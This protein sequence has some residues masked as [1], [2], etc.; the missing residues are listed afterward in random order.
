MVEVGN[1]PEHVP[2]IREFREIRDDLEAA[3]EWIK[4]RGGRVDS[5]RLSTYLSDLNALEA[6]WQV[7]GGDAL[8]RQKSHR[9]VLNSLM[10]A[11]AIGQVVKILRTQNPVPESINDK[12]FTCVCGPILPEDENAAASSNRA[13]NFFFELRLLALFLTAGLPAKPGESPDIE[14]AIDGR[15]VYLECKRAFSLKSLKNL[16][17]G[18][19]DQLLNAFDRDSCAIGVIAFD[20]TKFISLDYVSY[21]D[22]ATPDFDRKAAEVRQK[23]D[24]LIS[25]ELRRKIKNKIKEKIA[26]LIEYHEFPVYNQTTKRWGT[27]WFLEFVPL[28]DGTPGTDVLRRLQGALRSVS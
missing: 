5:S 9:R 15:V 8:I 14:T 6:S 24:P 17:S 4:K 2:Q 18:A 21:R 16:T 1:M 7:D 10:E 26:G 28:F 12:L 19:I 25:K 27:R 22:Q 11:D 23:C 3:I 13:R 20:L